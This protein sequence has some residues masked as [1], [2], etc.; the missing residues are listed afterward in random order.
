MIEDD[1]RAKWSAALREVSGTSDVRP[2]DWPKV[3]AKLRSF[4][5]QAERDLK[6]VHTVEKPAVATVMALCNCLAA[7]I[8]DGLS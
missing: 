8:E 2:I 1:F 3:A 6:V 7:A 4:G 5:A